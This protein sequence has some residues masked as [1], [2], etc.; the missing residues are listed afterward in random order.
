V[1]KISEPFAS[2]F[3]I[4][5]ATPVGDVRFVT[6]TAF[7]PG[8]RL[9]VTQFDGAP[10]SYAFNPVTGQLTD[11]RPA[12]IGF[13][14]GMAF[15]NHATPDAPAR[16]YMYVCRNVDFE[17]SI[18][19]LSDD[20]GNHV[21]GEAGETHVD[22]VRGVPFG[23]HTLDQIQVRNNQLYVGFGAR[24]NNGRGGDYSG[25]NYH[26]EPQGPVAGGYWSGNLGHTYGETSYNGAIATIRD[27]TRVPNVESAA[28]LRGGPNGTS[29]P[30]L[31]GRDTFMPGAPFAE[32]PYTSTADDK[33][34]VHSA[35][36]RNPYGLAIDAAGD[37]WFTNN[38]G[39]A[40]SD[41]DGTSTPHLL[42]L[43]DADLADDV[44]DQLFRAVA[45]GDYGY[46]NV[47]FRGSPN[48]P[49]VPVTSTTFDNLRSTDPNYGQLHDPANPIGLGPSSSANGFDFGTLDLTGLLATDAR[50]YALI[51]RWSGEIAEIEPGTDAMTFQDVVV[52]DPATGE[53]RR[54]AEGFDNP[55]DV[56]RDGAGGYLVA[57]YG[58]LGTIWRISPIASS[59]R[60]NNEQGGDWSDPANWTGPVPSSLNAV[61]SFTGAIGGPR[62]VNLD[63]QRFLGTLNFDNPN[64]YTIAGP[65]T[66]T[67]AVSAG[68]GAINVI[69]GSH[70]IATPVTFL[71]STTVHVA[72]AG[73]TLTMSGAQSAASGLT[74]TKTGPGALEVPYLRLDHVALLGGT[75]RLLA[76]GTAASTSRVKTL[77]LA[78]GAT[79][80]VRLDITDNALVIDH[81]FEP[82]LPNVAAQVRSAYAG[83][84]WTGPGIGSSLAD[85]S[86]RAVGFADRNALAS[87]PAI[88][89]ATDTTSVLVRLTRYGDADLSGNVN[90]A[91]F[92]VL[93]SNFGGTARLWQHG[94]FT[95]DG[96]VNLN[97]FNRLASNFGLSAAGTDVTPGDWAAL[98]SAVPEP[99]AG[100]LLAVLAPLVARR[101]P[102]RFS[103]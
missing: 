100:A 45:G 79:P 61:V 13:G 31:A 98:A 84:A 41:G 9:Y 81:D 82:A 57:D 47:N 66:L 101:R 18:T 34:V 52:V 83:G 77:R 70:T 92:N 55:L 67:L 78:G 99:V 22:I 44:H 16:D 46:D 87:V 69:S 97:D 72:R 1:P 39:R 37:L 96:V 53:V 95:Y 23:D 11:K 38:F 63:V 75:T 59:S 17:G 8:G 35:G 42:D 68:R 5:S 30:L 65:G 21:W 103:G 90:L 24:S 85:A 14:F 2:R 15:A 93:A 62:Q 3:Q 86:Q 73:D 54:L 4:T 60:W 32:L 88:F 50:E 71:S 20:N 12:G 49:S 64:R 48:F 102:A 33:F 7:G 56:E 25:Q 76:N 94:D 10:W 80:T 58:G 91:D 19:R 40:D 36:T 51:S 43:T 26:D 74:L 89:G 6:Q 29:G 28:Q 27:L